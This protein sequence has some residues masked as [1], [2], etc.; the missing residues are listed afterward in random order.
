MAMI[1]L[2]PDFGEFSRLLNIHEVRYL[3]VGDYAVGYHGYVRATADTDVW[4]SRERK[5]AEG[6]V[7]ALREFGFGVNGLGPDQFLEEG[8][9]I[10]MDVPPMRI[11]ILTS[12]SGVEFDECYAERIVEEWDDVK[13]NIL[14]LSKLKENKR[15]SGRPKD[16]ADLDYL[17]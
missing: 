13:V 7:A 3:L 16:L 4:V 9:V 6:L 5:N 17:E 2:P 14:S 15:A 10:R 1:P 12:I 8:R 11:E